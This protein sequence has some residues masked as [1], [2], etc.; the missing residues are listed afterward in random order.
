MVRFGPGHGASPVGPTS[1][2]FETERHSITYAIVALEPF[3]ARKCRVALTRCA[4]QPQASLASSVS[5]RIR[6]SWIACTSSWDKFRI[7]DACMCSPPGSAKSPTWHDF[8]KFMSEQYFSWLIADFA[9][10][11]KLTGLSPRIRDQREPTSRSRCTCFKPRITT[12]IKRRGSSTRVDGADFCACC[13][14]EQ[15]FPAPYRH[16]DVQAI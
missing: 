4:C 8:L 12:R 11:R 5:T 3:L 6:S 14:K 7:I 9:F 13:V 15:A 16:S 1:L 10:Q 2:N